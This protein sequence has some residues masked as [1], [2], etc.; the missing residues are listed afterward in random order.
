MPPSPSGPAGGGPGPPPSSA[1]LTALS[2]LQ[3]AR[4]AA[5]ELHLDPWEF[6]VNLAQLVVAGLSCEE[7][8]GLVVAGLA[9]CTDERRRARPDRRTFQSAADLVLSARSS[10]ILT[11]AGERFLKQ[12]DRHVAPSDNGQ[13]P[14]L[15]KP[16]WNIDR[17]QL[18]YREQLVK[19]YRQPA[20]LQETIL[21]TFEEDSW[22]PRI[23]DP[24][25]KAHGIVPRERL[26]DTLKRMNR[27]QLVPLLLFR[28]DG[29]GEGVEWE[30]R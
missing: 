10:F 11:P 21:A 28:R 8:R 16:S 23:D 1:I 29:S 2:F 19:W 9:E 12:W 4:D 30:G 22:P 14:T 25:P 17:R 3:R 7:V 26:H 18:W 20:V 27:D 5:Q 24:L 6:A 15:L 13:P